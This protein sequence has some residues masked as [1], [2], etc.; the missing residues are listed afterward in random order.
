MDKIN[1]KEYDKLCELNIEYEEE[2][3]FD[4]RYH[5]HPIIN[6]LFERSNFNFP[7]LGNHD[8]I[9]GIGKPLGETKEFK[10]PMKYPELDH[11]M[12]FRLKDMDDFY[13]FWTIRGIFNFPYVSWEEINSIR[14]ELGP[15]WKLLILNPALIRYKSTFAK[16]LAFVL[17]GEPSFVDELNNHIKTVT[18]YSLFLE[19]SVESDVPPIE[20]E[21][22]DVSKD[23]MVE[24]I[25]DD[26]E[27]AWNMLLT[28]WKDNDKF[29]CTQLDD[30]YRQFEKGLSFGYSPIFN[31][32]KL[33]S[34]VPFF[35]I[36]EEYGITLGPFNYF[37]LDLEYFA[38]YTSPYI[39]SETSF[40]PDNEIFT[41]MMGLNNE[42]NDLEK[43]FREGK[44][45]LTYEK[46]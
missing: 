20:K 3:L 19:Y 22:V 25:M 4:Y 29:H 6:N 31:H 24:I 8:R 38:Y 1:E 18:G 26:S 41:R 34:E 10:L 5:V 32:K 2:A 16:G 30:A 40:Y 13:E 44:F 42:M 17:N 11:H 9:N 7:L 27:P 12:C 33:H 35:I 36:S 39:C 21:I 14:E 28:F 45:V 23:K 43:M 37:S 46:S 15:A